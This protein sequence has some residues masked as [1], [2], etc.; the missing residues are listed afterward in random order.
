[1]VRSAAV[2][3]FL[4]VLLGA[5][6]A[7]TLHPRLVELGTLEIWK[8]ASLY[9]LIHATALLAVALAAPERRWTV[10][11]WLAGITVFSG[12]LYVLAVTDMRWLGAITPVGG[13]LLLGG[14]AALGRR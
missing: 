2:A 8:T 9:H 10:F 3:G 7:H 5:F 6:G 13:L 1:M 11:L 12:S 14:W 4:A